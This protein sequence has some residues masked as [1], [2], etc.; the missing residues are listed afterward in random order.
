MAIRR[1]HKLKKSRTNRRISSLRAQRRS[2]RGL[3]I[4]PL[5]DRRLLATGPQLVGIQPNVGE[6]LSEGQVRDTVPLELRFLFNSAASIDPT[7][8]PT[9]EMNPSLFDSIQITRSG[10]DGTFEQASVFSDF[11]TLGAV[12]IEFE[13]QAS[14]QAGSLISIEVTKAE[15][16][17]SRTP[18]L[19]VDGNV[20]QITLNT[21]V[22]KETRASDLIAAINTD[23]AAS[24]LVTARLRSGSS[25]TDITTPE[26][27]YSP[28]A[29][30]P[31]NAATATSSFHVPGLQVQ[32]TAAQPGIDG[33]GI[34]VQVSKSNLGDSVAPTITTSD[35]TIS[36]QLNSNVTTP[37]T[38]QELVDAINSDP[39]ASALVTAHIRAGDVDALL[40]TRTINYSP[41]VLTGA[42]DVRVEPGYLDLGDSP[43][44]VVMRFKDHLPDDVYMIEILGGGQ[45]PLDER[46]W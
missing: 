45:S 23:A 33:N 7:S 18:S 37:T 12:Q 44:E 27:T 26:I 28:L 41:I 16:G 42:N 38:A 15:L 36:I 5:E 22:G 29:M 1:S 25:V 30:N 32:L 13:A 3:R 10:L 9:D 43:R 20:I 2:E 11:N 46:Q 35:K 21:K 17:D 39:Q 24:S 31:A 19:T 6:L 8:L 40:G 34:M 14:G 4:E